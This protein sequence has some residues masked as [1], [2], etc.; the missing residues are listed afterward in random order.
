MR[1]RLLK[2]WDTLRSSIWFVPTIM[3]ILAMG[4]A[5][6]STAPM[7]HWAARE[8]P[9]PGGSKADWVGQPVVIATSM[10]L[11][12]RLPTPAPEAGT[13]VTEAS[14]RTP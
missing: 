5:L 3:A 4:L 14:R 2:A 12:P 9:R 7:K 1:S 13:G 6:V 10:N 8:S 11:T